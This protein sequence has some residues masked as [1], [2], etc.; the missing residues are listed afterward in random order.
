MKRSLV[1]TLVLMVLATLL[2]GGCGGKAGGDAGK[3]GQGAATGQKI[4]LKLGHNQSE[5]SPRHL[6][7]VKFAE[8]VKEKTNGQVEVQIYPNETLGSEVEMVEAIQSGTL[9][10]QVVGLPILT[11]WVPELGVFGLPFLFQNADEAYATVDGPVG[12]KLKALTD[13]KGFKLLSY[14]DLGFMQIT[15]NKRPIQKP[16]DIKGLKMRLQQQFVDIET[17]KAL[18]ASVVTMPFSELYM[19]LSQGVVDGEQNPVNGIYDAKFYEVQKYLT[20]SNHIYTSLAVIASRKTWDKLP[21]N[22]QEAITAAAEE[23]KLVSRQETQKLE[24]TALDKL[25]AAGMQVNTP[26]LTAFQQ[27]VQPVYSKVSDKIGAAT[28]KETRDFV[29]SKRRK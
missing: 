25:K 6:A 20:L 12:Q 27:A 2:L 18:G 28:I 7:A 5:T 21:A 1:V 10:L 19:A 13:S 8:L 23:A 26:D 22:A 29:T 24:Q 11:N 15:N 9:D 17:F 16:E 4:V 14:W 3:G